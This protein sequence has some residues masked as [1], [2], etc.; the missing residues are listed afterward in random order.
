MKCKIS[1]LTCELCRKRG[2]CEPLVAYEQMIDENSRLNNRLQQADNRIKSLE[3]ELDN[4]RKPKVK[5]LEPMTE[6]PACQAT[7]E[8]AAAGCE[9]STACSPPE[10]KDA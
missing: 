7:P 8:C 10:T 5:P 6:T 9:A 4:A 1:N 3:T 2:P